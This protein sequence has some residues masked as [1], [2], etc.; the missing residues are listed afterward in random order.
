[1]TYQHNIGKYASSQYS[2]FPRFNNVTVNIKKMTVLAILCI[3][4]QSPVLDW[5][6][7]EIYSIVL[8]VTRLTNDR[9][10]LYI[11]AKHHYIRQEPISVNK[12]WLHWLLCIFPYVQCR[13]KRVKAFAQLK[14]C[15]KCKEH[16]HFSIITPPPPV[17]MHW[18]V[19]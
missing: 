3:K 11:K 19:Q 9:K 13:I 2:T 18:P 5:T 12:N 10:E 8:F 15:A 1:M 6:A 17:E 7:N 14:G 16:N 4:L